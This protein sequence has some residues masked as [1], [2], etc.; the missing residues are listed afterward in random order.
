MSISVLCFLKLGAFSTFLHTRTHKWIRG[1]ISLWSRLSLIFYSPVPP[2]FT[3]AL[4]L[5]SLALEPDGLPHQSKFLES[6]LVHV[7]VCACLC[8]CVHAHV[9][10]HY[11]VFIL[12]KTEKKRY[13]KTFSVSFTSL[14]LLIHRKQLIFFMH[15]SLFELTKWHNQNNVSALVCRWDKGF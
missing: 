1:C 4:S 13:L 7:C 2:P 15:E 8:V 3:D 9:S 14:H 11:S 5:P 6:H 10:Q 12:R